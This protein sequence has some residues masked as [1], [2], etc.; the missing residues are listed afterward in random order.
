MKQ[1]ITVSELINSL[2]SLFPT[3]EE[4]NTTRVALF[5][6]E[7]TWDAP[8]LNAYRGRPA[9]YHLMRENPHTHKYA[10]LH[11]EFDSRF[12]TEYTTYTKDDK[13]V[14]LTDLEV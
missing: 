11:S 7:D 4:R 1:A 5:S 12:S 3:E 14:I 13:L 9:Q 6:A 2:I 10:P 8:L